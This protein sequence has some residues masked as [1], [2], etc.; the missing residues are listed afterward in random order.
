M[1]E[2]A[3]TP[4]HTPA[5]PS[6]W[7]EVLQLILSI[8]ELEGTREG[9]GTLLLL[10]L[11]VMII[12][13]RGMFL[14]PPFHRNVYVGGNP[15]CQSTFHYRLVLECMEHLCLLTEHTACFELAKGCL[16]SNPIKM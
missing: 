15:V 12:V 5:I 7:D 16:F 1:F 8:L 6:L 2:M 9:C 14:K 4:L 10:K 11:V 3:H 13:L